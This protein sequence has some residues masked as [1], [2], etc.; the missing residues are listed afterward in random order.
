ME[1]EQY[2]ES[3]GIPLYLYSDYT[4]A[5]GDQDNFKVGE[6][7]VRRPSNEIFEILNEVWYMN[8]KLWDLLNIK[9]VQPGKALKIAEEDAERLQDMG[10]GGVA[11][12]N[13]GVKLFSDYHANH[14]YTR[15]ETAAMYGKL[16]ETLK[17]RLGSV[18]FY[19]PNDYMW[20][21]AD[22][23]F[24]IPMRSTQFMYSTDTV[25][26]LQIVLHGYVEYYAPH[27][28]FNANP[29]EDMLRMIEYGAYP[30]FYLTHEPSWK[31]KETPS[32]SLFTS[33]FDDW[34]DRIA[35][36]YELANRALA[37]VQDAEIVDR[38]VPEY[39]VVEVKYSN[40]VTILVN[41][42]SKDVTYGGLT[43]KAQDFAVGGVKE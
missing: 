23:L 14:T 42:T 2:L 34:K 7:A 43:A 40:G 10:I 24:H 4:R 17:N 27:A 19:E 5:Y 32:I 12:A 20:K 41:Y 15:A 22:R 28:N 9:F 37:S 25:P 39:G 33:K 16:T 8:E 3:E 18:A 36:T 26:F 13:T 6:D 29:R 35:E 31:L 11:I 30:S 21:Y 38:T 1:L